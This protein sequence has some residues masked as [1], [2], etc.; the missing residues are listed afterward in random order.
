MNPHADGSYERLAAARQE[1]DESIS[2]KTLDGM[3]EAVANMTVL[4]DMITITRKKYDSLMADRK[5]LR[6]LEAGGVD[7][8]EWY[9]EATRGLFDDDNDD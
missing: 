6:A 1:V 4:P 8:W 9:G 7:N 2:Q 5:L 3:D